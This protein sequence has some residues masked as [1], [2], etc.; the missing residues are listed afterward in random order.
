MAH[1]IVDSDAFDELEAAL[2]NPAEP[3]ESIKEAAKL[4][5]KL[6]PSPAPA[7]KAGNVWEEIAKDPRLAVV[8]RKV[9]MRDLYVIAD[10]IRK[11]Y[12]EAIRALVANPHGCRFCDYG[13]LRKPENPVKGHDENCPFAAAEV[14]TQETRTAPAQKTEL[15]PVAWIAP[16]P[17]TARDNGFL[18][19]MAWQDG[20]FTSPLV[21]LSDAAAALS[22]ERQRAD[23]AEAERDQWRDSERRRFFAC[24][25]ALE[26]A[27]VAE[28]Q[29]DSLLAESLALNA[30]LE[31]AE[32][33]VERLRAALAT[34]VD[35]I[36]Q[37]RADL[38]TQRDGYDDVGN[39]TASKLTTKAIVLLHKASEPARAALPSIPKGD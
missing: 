24:A 29:Y 7:Q 14:L 6:Y 32:A 3:T 13:V 22:E 8:L 4:L 20:E 10:H 1:I 15:V 26:R 18:D 37:M 12:R 23:A 27:G 9:A 17:D 36:E 39:E 2:T 21:R 35:D 16:G 19:A 38:V 11:P 5:R 34:T 30:R 31:A 28:L 25:A 33:T